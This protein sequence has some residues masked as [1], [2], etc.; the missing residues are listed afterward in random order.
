[1]KKLVLIDGNAIIHRAYHALPVTLT[2]RMNEPIN[3]VY[4]FANILLR[5]ISDLRPTHIA[6]AFDTPEPTFRHKEF[7][8]YQAQRPEADPELKGQF[9]KVREVVGAFNIPIYEQK[10]YE[11]DDLIGTLARQGVRVGEQE[12]GVDEVLIV[13]GDR[14]IL[15]LVTD[16]VRLYMP[17]HGLSEGKIY[18]KEE[19]VERMGVT[20]SQ[21]VDYKALVGDPSDNYKGVPGI[22]PKTAEKLLGEYGTLHNIYGHIDDLPKAVAKKLKENKESAYQ[23]QKLAKIITDMDIV[24]DID[25]CNKWQ[26]DSP[27]VMG[28]FEQYGFKSLPRRAKQLA[29]QLVS[30]NQTSMF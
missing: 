3:A 16:K 25:A 20:P 19:T 15:Q 6:V 7:E 1:M 13:T 26:I 4:G 8:D 11:A 9:T 17:T 5:V 28:V 29:A 12:D 30:E 21:I 27:E 10:G 23:S 22:G 2:D 24:F 18:G 14:D